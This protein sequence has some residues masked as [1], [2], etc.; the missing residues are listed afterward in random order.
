M[1]VTRICPAPILQPGLMPLA[2]CVRLLA[3]DCRPQP[4]LDSFPIAFA[5]GLMCSQYALQRMR[6]RHVAQQWPKTGFAVVD[7]LAWKWRVKFR[8]MFWINIMRRVLYICDRLDQQ[9]DGQPLELFQMDSPNL[10]QRTGIVT[11]WNVARVRLQSVWDL[12]NLW[13]WLLAMPLK[14][15]WAAPAFFSHV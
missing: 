3:C 12:W 13:S 11:A 8:R 14:H 2:N 9:P 1:Y 10:S 7:A 5:D 6:R 15:R 4:R